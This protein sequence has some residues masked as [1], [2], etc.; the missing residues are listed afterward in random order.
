MFYQLPFAHRSQTSEVST[1]KIN[2]FTVLCRSLLQPY[3]NRT[4]LILQWRNTMQTPW[5]IRPCSIQLLQANS[6][7][8]GGATRFFD[9]KCSQFIDLSRQQ[10][11]INK[12]FDWF[13][14][15]RIPRKGG[16]PVFIVVF[17]STLPRPLM[18]TMGMKITLCRKSPSC[19]CWEFTLTGLPLKEVPLHRKQHH[20]N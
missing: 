18:N 16:F 9:T 20:C 2:R 1:R 6:Q 14:N 15:H 7:V 4:N 13:T 10:R 12:A 17:A 8:G 11:H 19:M 5:Y 3:Q